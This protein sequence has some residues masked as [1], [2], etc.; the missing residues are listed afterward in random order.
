[1]I[2]LN[3]DWIRRFHTLNVHYSSEIQCIESSEFQCVRFNDSMCIESKRNSKCIES[4]KIQ[5]ES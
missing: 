3:L 2:Q 5:S 4:K 1:M